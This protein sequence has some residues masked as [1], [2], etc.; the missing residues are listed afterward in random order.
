[1]EEQD[2]PIRTFSSEVGVDLD[3]DFDEYDQVV[4]MSDDILR[5]QLTG[6][7]KANHELSRKNFIECV[8]NRVIATGISFSNSNFNDSRL[9]NCVFTN[10]DMDGGHFNTSTIR[11]SEFTGCIHTLTN[12]NQTD[13]YNV[14][15]RDCDF[16]RLLIKNC[17]FYSCTFDNCKTTNKVFESCI[18]IGCMFSN[19][20]LQLQSIHD[21]F[22]MSS[23]N[24][25]EVRFRSAR[26]SEDYEY[27]LPESI[28]EH[29]TIAGLDSIRRF[30][31]EFFLNG[32]SSRSIKVLNEAFDQPKWII[33]CKTSR[34]FTVLLDVFAEFLLHLYRSNL[35]TIHPILK[36]HNLTSFIVNELRD[37]K[38]QGETLYRQIMAIHLVLARE[39]ELFLFILDNLYG[40]DENKLVFL[41]N[42]PPE[43]ELFENELRILQ[44]HIRFKVV[45]AIPHNS[46]T[47]VTI[48][49][50][51][52]AQYIGLLSLFLASRFKFQLTKLADNMRMTDQVTTVKHETSVNSEI[53]NIQRESLL[54]SIGR[55]EENAH[56]YSFQLRSIFPGKMY[57]SLQ[58]D[59]DLR[60][61]HKL[62]KIFTDLITRDRQTT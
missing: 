8:L 9:E 44:N 55:D 17:R 29:A 61:V 34:T 53:I 19:I 56:K 16:C 11:D 39:I 59:I 36:F 58:I 37:Q 23:L 50:M 27:V 30:S 33:T 47:E 40:K 54:V 6:T 21:N 46:P 4:I 31:V 14:T 5:S 38:D 2:I 26:T 45:S 57:A 12:F 60:I 52:A 20:E 22:G 25:S 10:C 15:F 13:F 42:L 41:S 24:M 1:M 49:L 48:D 18:L 51:N 3:I 43:P 7:L 32:I 62:Q 35:I 28:G